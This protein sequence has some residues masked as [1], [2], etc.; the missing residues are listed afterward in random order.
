MGD[1]AC[2][3][4]H[5]GGASAHGKCASSYHGLT[6]FFARSV[7]DVARDLIGCTVAHGRPPG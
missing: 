1:A 2:R 4:K 7:H 3:E 5:G 6:S